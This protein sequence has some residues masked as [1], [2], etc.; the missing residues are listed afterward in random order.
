MAEQAAPALLSA[1]CCSARSA[2]CFLCSGGAVRAGGGSGSFELGVEQRTPPGRS[3][4]FRGQGR[5][6][7]LFFGSEFIC[8]LRWWTHRHARARTHARARAHTHTHTHRTHQ[9]HRATALLYLSVLAA[10]KTRQRNAAGIFTTHRQRSRKHLRPGV[11]SPG[12]LRREAARQTSRGARRFSK[13]A[14]R[15]RTRSSTYTMRCS[16]HSC[17]GARQ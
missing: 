17:T 4:K 11:W 14:M 12:S 8:W 7:G 3:I 10:L 13:R 2:P 15:A 6:W 1:P 9:F 5:G 16:T